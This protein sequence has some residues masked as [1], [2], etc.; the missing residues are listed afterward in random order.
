MT[1]VEVIVAVVILSLSVVA[2]LGALTAVTAT[3]NQSREA[4]DVGAV[5]RN[6]LEYV[7]SRPYVPCSSFSSAT[8]P[9]LTPSSLTITQ[10]GIAPPTIVQITSLDGTKVF[11][12]NTS[13]TCGGLSSDPGLQL[14]EIQDS[15]TDK[16]VTT[17]QWV[18][19]SQNQ[20]DE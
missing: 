10:N 1:L 6:A 19:V 20:A 4:A 17:T 9:Y 11:W 7:K 2:T 3:S 13:P 14:V 15:S 8:P 12:P 18:V 16:S 5:A